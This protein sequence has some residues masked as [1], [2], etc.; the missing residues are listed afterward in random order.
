M[1][2]KRTLYFL[3]FLLLIS[4]I[5]FPQD[6]K[7]IAGQLLDMADE[8]YKS[9]SAYIQARDAYLQVL[10]YDP[11]NLKANYMAGRLYLET[12]DKEKAT[13]YLVKVYSLNPGYTFDLLYLIGRS[14]QFG[15]DFDNAIDYYNR[16]L[17]KVRS[18]PG[19]NGVDFVSTDDAQKRIKEC[20]TGISLVANPLN[21]N[22]TN[23]GDGVNSEWPDYGPTIDENETMLIFTSRRRQGNMNENVYED[24]FPYEDIYI[25]RKVDDKW[26]PAKNM[27]PVINTPYFESSLTLTKDGKQLYLYLD[28]N[29]GDIY[30]SNLKPD[31]SWSA[32]VPL[33]GNINSS[34]K[35]TSVSISPNGNVI[36]F[37]SDRPGSIGGLD[38]YYSIKNKRGIWLDVKNM[39]PVIN[40]P[41][42]D[43]FPFIDYDSKTLYFSSKG[44][45]G[46]G[47]F[48][49]YK[50][51]YDSS[52]RDWITPV[53]IGYPMNTP[54]NDISFIATKDG[55][56]GYFSSV[57]EDGLGY[58]DIYMF[59]I[60][61]EVRKIDEENTQM[62]LKPVASLKPVTINVSVTDESG[63]PL[64]A[65][66]K[67]R[68]CDDR[69]LGPVTRI[70]QGT[71][72]IAANFGSDKNCTLSAEKDGYMY[73]NKNIT[74]PGSSEINRSISVSL[75]LKNLTAGN[76]MVLHNIYFDFDKST[77]RPESYI[78][79]NKMYHML[80]ENSKLIAEIAGYTDN[81]GSEDYNYRL[82]YRRAKAVVDVLIRKGIDPIRIRAHGY[83]EED[84]IASN[85]DEIDGR[86]L[87]RRV[88]FH[89]MRYLY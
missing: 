35:E 81:I 13:Q 16:Y 84:P 22:I 23:V 28:T 49:I 71:Y 42:D 53:N 55:K 24:N 79:I 29:A 66:V 31:G 11:D 25:S 1:L 14:Y 34:S 32:P 58:Q 26:G 15:L 59:T 80:K 45:Q 83:G 76:S 61:E 50:S 46:M 52:K 3:P 18:N 41:E 10:D 7:E 39:G 43:D 37:A 40:T 21:Y 75:I 87:N 54:D 19:Y 63:N 65:D 64:D 69:Y 70:S 12:V 36:Y 9:T 30:V 62:P 86:E 51:V 78:E 2:F 56:R 67:F 4:A 73:V 88:E 20:N 77:L 85:D 33:Q 89:V 82:S 8:I 38:L 60:P 57:R 17:D 44:H 68:N 74:I 27:G 5:A 47:G 6:N 72:I 48:D